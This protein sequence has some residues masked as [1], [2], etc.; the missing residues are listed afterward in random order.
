MQ[1]SR[2][3]LDYMPSLNGTFPLTVLRTVFRVGCGIEANGKQERASL[4][5]PPPVFQPPNVSD[6]AETVA[7]TIARSLC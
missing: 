4:T 7:L 6:A 1:G 2:L 3:V 5:I